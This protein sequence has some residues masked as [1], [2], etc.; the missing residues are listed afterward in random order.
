MVLVQA[1]SIVENSKYQGGGMPYNI[2]PLDSNVSYVFS[3]LI[4]QFSLTLTYDLVSH[5]LHVAR[6]VK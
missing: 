4:R 5:V 2:E 6:R 1:E 3:C